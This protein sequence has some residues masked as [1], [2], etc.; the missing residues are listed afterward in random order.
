MT[1][2][3]RLF[4]AN[5]G[6]IARRIAVSC[7][8]LGI[9]TVSICLKNKRPA[10]LQGLITEFC[11]VDVEDSA[12]YLNQDRMIEIAKEYSCDAIH[13]GFG[14]LSENAGFAKAVSEAGLNWVGPSHQAIE[15]MA[16]K[17]AARELAIKAS[18]P[19]VPGMEGVDASS[20]EKEVIDFVERTGYPVLLKAALGGG[21]KGMRVVREQGELINAMQR[22]SSEA[23]NSFGDGS[24]IVEKFLENP[25][26]VE[27]QILGD[28]QGNVRAI[29]D[30]DCSVQRRHQK[31]SGEITNLCS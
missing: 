27:V 9:E 7:H 23:L 8:K 5:R 19:C 24:L 16:S 11:E 29:G 30:R 15:A 25:R 22:A 4:I 20:S 2:I 6:E 12:L 31:I 14:F 26:H 17:S 21:G 18:V 28:K 3:K 10:F 1:Q 13:P